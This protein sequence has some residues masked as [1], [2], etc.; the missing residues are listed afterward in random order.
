[1]TL[2]PFVLPETEEGTSFASLIPVCAESLKQYSEVFALCHVTTHGV[3]ADMGHIPDPCSSPS[4]E[5][6]RGDHSSMA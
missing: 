6:Q 4:A 5:L 2:L 1:M 3:A